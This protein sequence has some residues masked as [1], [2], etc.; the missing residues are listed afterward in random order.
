MKFAKPQFELVRV[1]DVVPG[2]AR[3][4]PQSDG[5]V[6]G[7]ADGTPRRAGHRHQCGR[8]DV[9]LGSAMLT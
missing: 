8:S 1:F 3:N 7:H 6:L 5:R 4:R 2:G 9:L